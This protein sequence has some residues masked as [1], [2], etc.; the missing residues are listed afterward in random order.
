MVVELLPNMDELFI[1]AWGETIT[2]RAVTKSSFD[3]RGNATVSNSDSTTTAVVDLLTANSEL[4]EE[5]YA[6][7][8]M[9]IV[10]L[11][12][13]VTIDRPDDDKEY[14]IQ[15]NTNWFLV[16]DMQL[17]ELQGTTMMKRVRCARQ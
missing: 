6:Q 8:G 12:S 4:V 3:D 11:K 16:D 5:G 7:E 1:D 17:C 14:L 9:L 15:W 2:V 10:W 13:T